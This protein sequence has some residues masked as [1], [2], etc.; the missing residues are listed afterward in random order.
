MRLR[1]VKCLFKVIKLV[2]EPGGE[3]SNSKATFMTI[4]QL[5]LLQSNSQHRL[6]NTVPLRGDDGGQR[7]PP[8]GP[9]TGLFVDPGPTSQVPCAHNGIPTTPKETHT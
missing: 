3:L 9:I 4:A 2:V 7:V 6:R 8:T 1:E 5:C